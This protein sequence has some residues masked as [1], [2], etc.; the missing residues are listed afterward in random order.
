MR[1]L[2]L[3][4]W[5]HFA[6]LVISIAMLGIACSGCSSFSIAIECERGR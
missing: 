2:A 3:A 6:G 5:G 1:L 4:Y